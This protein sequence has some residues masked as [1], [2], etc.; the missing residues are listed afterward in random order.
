MI[1]YGLMKNNY[2]RYLN[3]RKVGLAVVGVNNFAEFYLDKIKELESEEQLKLTAVVITD[4]V[5]NA[6]KVRELR[7]EG[8]AIYSSYESLLREAKNCVDIIG[9][10][11][12]IPTHSEMAIKGMKAGY[13]ILLEKPPAPT[14]QEI[15]AIIKTEKETGRFCSIGFQYIHSHTIRKIK[16]IILDGKLG[17]IKEIA[18]KGFWPRFKSYYNRN[19]WAGKS[20]AMGQL[21]LDGPMHKK[22]LEQN[23]IKLIP[24]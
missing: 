13:N 7:Q 3:M 12:S 2:W 9:L 23:Y 15:D 20:V 6:D 11:I 10:P 14:V 16:Q 18:A 19:E 21:V 1:Y 17:E 4:Q 24:T 22:K 5:N 8:I